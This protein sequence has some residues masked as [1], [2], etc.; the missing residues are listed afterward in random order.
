MG[1]GV[2]SGLR[3]VE[4]AHPLTEYAGRL[5]VACGA[6]VFLVEPPEGAAT[7]RRRPQVPN[8]GESP[9]G[10]IPFLARNANK[11][12]RRHRREPSRG[13]RRQ[14][15][16]FLLC[17]DSVSEFIAEFEGACRELGGGASAS[18]RRAARDG[19][20]APTTPP[21]SSSGTSSIAASPSPRSSK[22]LLRHAFFRNCK[23]PHSSLDYLAPNDCLVAC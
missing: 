10:G 1:I 14:K 17:A 18:C 11:E 13:C 7:C 16:T 9:R 5:W 19:T 15:G 6:E 8:A 20:A 2:L 12:E 23:L 22:R 3:V 21:A 4:V